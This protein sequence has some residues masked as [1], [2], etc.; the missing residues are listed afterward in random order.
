M[1]K[2]D[3]IQY[4]S[5]RAKEYE[6]IYEKPERQEDLRF[7]EIYLK[8][9]FAEKTVLEIAC[10]TGFWTKHISETATF[11]LATDVNQAVI[12]VAKS[13]PYKSP[14]KFDLANIYD[15]KEIEAGFDSGFGGFIWSHIPREKLKL[16][17]EVFSSKINDGGTIVF[18]DNQFVGGSNTPINRKDD[19]LNTY[20]I[21]TLENGAHYEVLKNFPDD[22][23][24]LE[25]ITPL[26]FE[27]KIRRLKYFWIL[28][29]RKKGQAA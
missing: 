8:E 22:S 4:Y 6:K 20:Q 19:F 16:F 24:F 10:G 5:E 3:Q 28:S 13:K 15:L 9:M 29:F 26:G 14:V 27:V 25:L 18:I 2:L 21:R 12:E 17:L 1:P 11:I 7:L 23:E